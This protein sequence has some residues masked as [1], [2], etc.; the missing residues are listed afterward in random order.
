MIAE[1]LMTGEDLL[2]EYLLLKSNSLF[3]E[4]YAK[5]QP[6]LLK[7]V[8]RLVLDDPEA[9][10]IVQ[11]TF[12]A[13]MELDRPE[14]PI[15]NARSFLTKM[16]HANALDFKR[17]R[18]RRY[19]VL[20]LED[21]LEEESPTYMMEDREF[22]VE[23]QE[24]VNILREHLDCLPEKH[25]KAIELHYGQGMSREEVADELGVSVNTV[26]SWIFR[27]VETVRERM[28]T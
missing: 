9:E 11:D 4:L 7:T 20:S 15:R 17:A 21:V 5:Y 26:W 25:A 24:Q 14:E 27:G 23:D 8:K 19:K 3:E 10:D 2:N 6:P 22:S 13:L 16:A 18:H 28:G 12:V 1:D